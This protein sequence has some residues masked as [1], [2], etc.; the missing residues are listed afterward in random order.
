MNPI[1]IP[2]TT[3]GPGSQ[4]DEGDR[5]D[6]M[7]MPKGMFR[8]D[9]IS[10]PEP[11]DMASLPGARQLIRQLQQAITRYEYGAP[12]IQLPIE[13]RAAERDLINQILGEGEVSI[14]VELDEGRVQ[15]QESVLTGIWRVQTLDAD[16][17]LVAD[18]LEVADIPAIVR[19]RSAAGGRKLDV[20]LEQLPEGVQNA[21]P[22]LL[23]IQDKLDEYQPGQPPHVINLSLLP[24]TDADLILLGERLGVGPAIILSRGYGN[25]RIGSTAL[26][27]VWWIKYYN[28]QD[29]LILNT[30]EIVDMP[31]VALAAP[32]DIEDSIERVNEIAQLYSEEHV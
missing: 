8:H 7:E 29:A 11:E 4:P 32:E 26:E 5:F 17:R 1:D 16:G 19:E 12:G 10:L 28:S 15:V 18:A 14:N 6:F 9:C 23:E 13:L 21:P 2:I 22:L 30:I 31:E 27:G 20:S 24:L 3:I 25:C